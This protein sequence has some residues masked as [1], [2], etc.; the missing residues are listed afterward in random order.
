MQ[1]FD[2]SEGLKSLVLFG[3]GGSGREIACMVNRINAVKPTYHLMGF[4]DDAP[5]MTGQVL[6]GLPVLGGT[7]WLL[8]HKDHVFCNVTIGLMKPRVQVCSKLEENGVMFETLIDPTASI[9]T[10]VE[11]G[12]GCIINEHCEL[13]VNIRVGKHVFLN[14]DTCLGHDDVIGN[15]TIC[16]PHT[17]ISGACTIGERVMI[18]GM[19]FI[20][21]CVKVGN[22]AVIAP[23]SVVYGRV[24]EGIHVIGNPARKIDL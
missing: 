16:N 14:S 11:I 23:G 8:E 17:V 12:T 3:A 5:N 18:G 7:E 9:G 20:V 19:S 1:N 24:R 2:K 13:P 22:D 21:Q 4:V 10:D 15:Y 6:N